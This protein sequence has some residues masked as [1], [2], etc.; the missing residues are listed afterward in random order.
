MFTTK[1]ANSETFRAAF[2][3]NSSKSMRTRLIET[4]PTSIG[5]KCLVCNQIGTFKTVRAALVPDR[6]PSCWHRASRL[7]PTRK[8]GLCRRA[9]LPAAQCCQPRIKITNNAAATKIPAAKKNEPA[10]QLA[11]AVVA[12]TVA[13]LLLLLLLLAVG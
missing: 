9:C 10:R 6:R 8:P 1:S 5:L 2:V 12:A 3:A 13:S 4:I 7:I 11:S